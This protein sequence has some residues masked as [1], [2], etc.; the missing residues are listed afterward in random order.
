MYAEDKVLIAVMNNLADW[1]LVQSQRWYRLPARH[2][3]PGSPHFD[4][5]AFYFTREFG[6]DRWAVHYY[7]AIEGHELVTRRDLFPDQPAHPHAGHWYYRLQLGSPQHRIPP[8]V[9][10][11]WRRITFLVTSGD[12]FLSANTIEQLRESHDPGGN[13]YVKLRDRL[14]GL[15]QAAGPFE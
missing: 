9:S 15:F 11:R 5:L 4:W 14:T 2:A 7:A 13:L 6:E 8:I 1:Q 12:R 3:P 10:Q